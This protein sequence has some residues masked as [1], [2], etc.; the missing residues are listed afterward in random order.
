MASI[1]D[2]QSIRLHISAV[3][4]A[5]F[6]DADGTA[7]LAERGPYPVCSPDAG[8][9]RDNSASSDGEA[10]FLDFR[11]RIKVQRDAAIFLVVVDAVTYAF[12]VDLCPASF[13]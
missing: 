10:L 9:L 12:D 3:S 6:R 2:P 1:V 11:V 5:A 8:D 4:A 13:G 7:R